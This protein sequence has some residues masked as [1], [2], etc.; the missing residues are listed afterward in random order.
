MRFAIRETLLPG[1]SPLE[2]FQ[3]AQ[4][5]GFTAVE[6]W[7]DDMHDDSIFDYARAMDSTGLPISSLYS[8]TGNSV[9]AHDPAVRDPAIDRVRQVL[10]DA[11]D[12]MIP[13]V[14]IV[15]Q[16]A[17]IPASLLPEQEYALMIWF[18]R[19]VNDLAGAM[20]TTLCLLPLSPAL[21]RVLN[22]ARQTFA[23]LEEMRFHPAVGMMLDAQTLNESVETI[24]PDM[25]A[26]I[27]GLYIL[28]DTERVPLHP[29]WQG[30]VILVSG[31]LTRDNALPIPALAAQRQRLAGVFL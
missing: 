12:L 4:T 15:P 20:N 5:A 27:R 19:V 2:R 7:A 13:N 6:V 8:G 1:I 17:A 26:H 11:H 9:L 18:V 21:A 24:S 31:H 16:S 3:A 28:P 25:L 14:V 23:A 10:S 30:D 29:D 22:T